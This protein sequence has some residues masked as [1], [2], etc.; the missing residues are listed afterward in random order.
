VEFVAKKRT[1][2]VT[3]DGESFEVRCPNIGDIE[4]LQERIQAEGE[5]KSLSIYKDFFADIG[6]PVA[7][8]K[9]FD[10]IDFQDFVEFL[11]S[12]KKK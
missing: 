3:I 6:L 1:M 12:P 2:K 8:Y 10:M 5:E 9:K 7:A 4:S 11:M